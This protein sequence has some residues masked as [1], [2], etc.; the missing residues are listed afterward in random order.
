MLPSSGW[1]PEVVKSADVLANAAISQ[2]TSVWVFLIGNM[3]DVWTVAWALNKLRS[4]MPA[5]VL[6]KGLGEKILLDLAQ[7][8]ADGLMTSNY[9]TEYFLLK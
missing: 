3:L 1:I 7:T 4:K 9:L 2:K 8:R 5:K 6:S